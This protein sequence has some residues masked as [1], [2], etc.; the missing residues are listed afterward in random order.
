MRVALVAWFRHNV[1]DWDTAPE[2]SRLDM[3]DMSASDL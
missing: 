2:Y 1:V 3:L